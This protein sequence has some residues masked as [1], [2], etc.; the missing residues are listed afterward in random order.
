MGFTCIL[1]TNI[2]L[3]GHYWYFKQQSGDE[4]LLLYAEKLMVETC[5]DQGLHMESDMS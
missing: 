3:V 4:R 5:F 1:Y 2:V